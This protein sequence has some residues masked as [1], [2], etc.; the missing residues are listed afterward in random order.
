MKRFFRKKI[1]I[2]MKNKKEKETRSLCGQFKVIKSRLST[3]YPI[4]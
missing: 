1:Y 2:K 4:K 3:N